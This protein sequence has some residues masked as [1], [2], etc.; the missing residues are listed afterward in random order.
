[1]GAR[2]VF[3]QKLTRRACTQALN[4]HPGARSLSHVRLDFPVG[5]DS[6]DQYA[7]EA[8]CAELQLTI[9]YMHL[10]DELQRGA[11]Y[12]VWWTPR[13]GWYLCYGA[14]GA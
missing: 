14:A 11:T 7:F 9:V 1:M 12:H 8:R 6:C 4:A 2:V 5:S 10:E 3:Q 13:R